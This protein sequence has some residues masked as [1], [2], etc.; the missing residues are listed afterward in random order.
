MTRLLLSTLLV[1][2]AI[3]AAQAGAATDST[4]R[5]TEPRR[6]NI[7]WLSSSR[8][9][10]VGDIVRVAIDEYALAEASK[11]TVSEASRD[12]QLGLG[13]NVTLEGKAIAGPADGSMEFSDRGASRSRGEASRGSRYVGEI[14]ARVIAITPE[15][16]L[17]IKGAKVIDVD[18]ARQEITL[19][20][21]VQPRDID[22]RDVVA[23]GAIAD[24]Q[25]VY[26]SRGLDKPKN[27]LLGRLVGILWP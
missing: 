9:F 21:I 20:G 18:K 16:L 13:A 11:A 2:P 7:S 25:I 27:G 26:T 23:S 5:A 10:R 15:G 6:R 8:E 12:R 3:A 22:T 4:A 1:M 19:T 24:A 17:Q 14:S